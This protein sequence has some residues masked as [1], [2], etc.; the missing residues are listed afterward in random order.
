MQIFLDTANLDDIKKYA[1]WG[2]VDG[3]TT[4]PSLIAKEGVSLE[5]RIKEIAEVV[6]GP[7]S[8]EVIAEDAKGMLKEGKEYA[9]WH[10][11]VIIK[12]PTT[13]EG[14][15]AVQEFD[16]EG[17]KCNVTLC[18]SANQ[19]LMVAKAGAFIVSP[20][21][22]RL[23]DIGENGMGLIEEITTIYH[24]YGYETQILVASVRST[25]HVSHAAQLGAD[26]ATIPAAILDKMIQHPLT[27]KGIEKFLADWETVKSKQK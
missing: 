8:S 11:N 10:P 3:V 20:F 12:V 2:I 18:F 4:N 13:S 15:I 16:K 27:D 26:I 14:L 17:I 24:N 5:K 1:A 7:I 22:G 21:V 25:E 9:K 23:D 6:D 19:A